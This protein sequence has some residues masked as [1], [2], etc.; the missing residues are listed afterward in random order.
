MEEEQFERVEFLLQSIRKAAWWCTAFVILT[1]LV[2]GC[3]DGSGT[4]KDGPSARHLPAV[5]RW[6]ESNRAMASQ[7]RERGRPDC[8]TV[9]QVVAR[10]DPAIRE[11]E[12]SASAPRRDMALSILE[13]VQYAEALLIVENGCREGG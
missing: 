6:M 9:L 13:T 2:A 4:N 12:R 8:V 11:L 7:I 10:S 3:V 1:A 5:A